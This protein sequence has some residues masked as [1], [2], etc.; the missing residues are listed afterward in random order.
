MPDLLRHWAGALAGLAPS[1][2]LAAAPSGKA[3]P[4]WNLTDWL[5]EIS[6]QQARM[7]AS[8]HHYN[9]FDRTARSLTV[10][11]I[12]A[13]TDHA[14]AVDLAGLLRR[15][16]YPSTSIHGL[17]RV[18]S[19]AEIGELVAEATNRTRQLAIGRQTP[20]M[21]GPR[22]DPALLPDDRLEALIQRHRD[23]QVVEALRAEKRRR[24]V[25]RSEASGV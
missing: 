1:P 14:Q 23:L 10:S 4:L 19:R 21:R 2:P 17:D 13:I 25:R 24:E 15:A 11:R 12:R 8:T 7:R 20:R 16:K 18:W 5:A 9:R 22:L 3:A 6:R